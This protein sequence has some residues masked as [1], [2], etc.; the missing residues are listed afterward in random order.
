[1]LTSLGILLAALLG[2]RLILSA[3][4]IRRDRLSPHIR[5]LEQSRDIQRARIE[6][7][8]TEVADLRRL[9]NLHHEAIQRGFHKRHEEGIA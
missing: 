9:V 4:A 3:W 5:S 7:L 2:A 1:M 8:R 6:A